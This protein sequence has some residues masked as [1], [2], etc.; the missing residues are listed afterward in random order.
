IVNLWG[1]NYDWPHNNWYAARKLPDGKWRFM[2][3]D[4]EWGFRG[5]P[6][7]PDNDSY[8]FI[9]SGGAYG[10]STQRKMFIALLGNPEYREYYQAEVRRH[11]DGALSDENVLRR[12]RQLRD[13]IAN[14]IAH[15][16]RASKYDIKVWHR[17]ID[18]VE[19]FGRIAGGNFRKWTNDYFAFRNK[20]VSNH[21]LTR[22]ENKAGYRHIVHVN[23]DGKWVELVAAPNSKN[24]SNSTLPFS[25][26][27]S[28]RPALFAL[29]KDER[30]LV[31]RGTDGHIYEYAS[32]SIASA[33]GQWT[34]QNL[35]R[36]LG[37]PKAAADPSVVVANSVPHVVYV[38]ELGEIRE[39]WFDGQWRQ[40]PLPAMPRAEGGIVA[41]LDGSMLRVIY[42]SMFGVP[43]E[44]S[45]NLDSATPENRSWRTEGVHRLP[46][47]GQPLGLTVNGRRNTVF[48]VAS[49]WPRRPPFLF[50]WNERRRVPGYFTYEGERNALVYAKE[51]GQRFKNQYHIAHTT[52]QLYGEFALFRDMKNERHYLA[53]RDPEGGIFESVLQGE[54]WT[55]AN[56]SE[57]A[58]A[59]RAKGSPI[60]WVNVKTGTRH[61]L[62][63]SEDGEVHQLSFDG[64]WTHQALS[65]KTSKAE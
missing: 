54:E 4:S 36:S 33:D 49:E 1:Q 27:A 44:Q 53:F 39:L 8:A 3:W 41:S 47:S 10:F 25:P 63:Q 6:Y 59:P 43:Y 21:G 62:Y 30:R 11:L 14:E 52:D 40:F 35:T 37:L 32:A 51:I 55:M 20:P 34:R 12:T 2:C 31:Y 22:L 42:R 50:D 65:P 15:E 28:G 18:E 60:G 7:K 46:A 9:D 24:W 38:D 5:G 29:T 17:E 57:M 56:P 16:Y 58:D 45:L 13:A 64:K 23:A 26:S 48:H 61:Y 19:E